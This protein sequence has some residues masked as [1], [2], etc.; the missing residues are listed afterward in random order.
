MIFTLQKKDSM[1]VQN[2]QRLLH[3]ASSYLTSIYFWPFEEIHREHKKTTRVTV[4]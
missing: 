3:F 2:V 1:T 4:S